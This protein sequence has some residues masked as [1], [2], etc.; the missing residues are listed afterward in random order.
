M[1]I[2][3][4]NTVQHI[5]HL[6]VNI[7]P[8][9][10]TTTQE[11]Q[12]AEYVQTQFETLGLETHWED[13]ASAK[14]GWRQFSAAALIGLGSELLF[15]LGGQIGALVAGL[16]MLV[17]A[18]SVLLE[19]HFK[20]SP[21]DLFIAKG[22]SQNVWA[23]LPARGPARRR[24]LLL[25][26]L[27]THRTPWFFIKPQRLAFFH[28]MTTL[29]VVAF[30]LSGIVYLLLAFVHA[31]AWVWFTLIL[32]PVY[33]ILLV[34]FWQPDTT[35]YTPGANDNASGASIVLSLAGQ[36]AKSPLENVE[37]WALCTGCE[38]VG[39][40]G[41]YAFLQKHKA[42]L[43]EMVA[44]NLDNVG[45]RG[46][47]V[48]YITTEGIVLPLKPSAELLRL[49]DAVRAERPELGA[50]SQPFTLLGT[51]ATC[52]LVNGIPALS[53][54]GLTKDGTIP[55]WHQATDTFEN[56]NSQAVENT[57]AFVLEM[58]KRL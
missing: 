12:A 21:L 16:F 34:L 9:G 14:S 19:S 37:V 52:L 17:T 26:H 55:N 38:E 40:R 5:R 48:C 13:F 3:L 32:V 25:A 58:L 54:V 43:R 45:G 36:L 24:V 31:G 6:S 41:I 20:P 22:N 46:V 35:P 2:I 47:G 53:F 8:R 57:E 23:H 29:G 4:S 18:A 15:L 50:Y 11:K 51:D 56:I 49:A 42:D 27:D 1:E 30:V 10:S 28:L 33:L 44:I 7:G 39:A